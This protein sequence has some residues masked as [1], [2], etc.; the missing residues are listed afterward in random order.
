MPYPRLHRD[1]PDLDAPPTFRFTD[2]AR[3]PPAR[4]ARRPHDAELAVERVQKVLDR[5]DELLDPLPFR[6]SEAEDEGPRAA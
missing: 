2:F 1:D 6:R 4:R 5:I 3:Q